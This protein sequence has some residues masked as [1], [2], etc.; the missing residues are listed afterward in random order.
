MS[1]S[2]VDITELQNDAIMLETLAPSEAHIDAFTMLWHLKPT[3]GD[4]E[5]QTP[6]QQTPPSRG[7]LHCLHMQLG[8]LGDHEL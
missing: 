3:I 4:G 7:T 1:H 2:L 6:P 8:D 5:L